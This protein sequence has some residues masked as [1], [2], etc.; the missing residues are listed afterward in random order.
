MN[1]SECEL[2]C[3]SAENR[4]QHPSVDV[5][6]DQFVIRSSTAEAES[7]INLVP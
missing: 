3:V 1:F 2:T 7:L 6:A 5:I 4:A